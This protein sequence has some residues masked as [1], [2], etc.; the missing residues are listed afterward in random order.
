MFL[1]SVTPSVP[2]QYLPQNSLID[3]PEYILNRQYLFLPLC[4][5]R[6]DEESDSEY[7]RDS[8]SDGSNDS[9]QERV[10]LN[11]SREQPKYPQH[12]HKSSREQLMAFQEGF[13]SDEGEDGSS[14][15]TLLFE[16]LEQDPPY[17]R[18]P[19]ANKFFFSIT[20]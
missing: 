16:Y 20:S 18:E 19:L 15:G 14:H 9:E 12:S 13:S 10:G 8:S 6:L 1:E 2:A 5:R 11:Y 4:G 3:G 7:L 17:C